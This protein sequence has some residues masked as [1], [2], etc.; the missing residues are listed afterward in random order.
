[1]IKDKEDLTSLV[2]QKLERKMKLGNL[3]NEAF[4]YMKAKLVEKERKS[5]ANGMNGSLM[6]KIL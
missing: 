5:N 3:I 4:V 6:F 2:N 1:L